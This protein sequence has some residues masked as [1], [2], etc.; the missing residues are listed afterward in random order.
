[1]PWQ[2]DL[3]GDGADL[4]ED[5]ALIPAA[6]EVIFGGDWGLILFSAGSVAQ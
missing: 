1:M 5:G 3:G 2:R 4:G 6:G